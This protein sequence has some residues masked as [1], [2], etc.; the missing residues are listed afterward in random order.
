MLVARAFGHLPVLG[1]RAV[2]A[3]E[4]YCLPWT[5]AR[6]VAG[7]VANRLAR[8]PLMS[9][10]WK[11]RPVVFGLGLLDAVQNGRWE[12]AVPLIVLAVLTYTT[13][14]LDQAWMRKLDE[15]GD[16]RVIDEDLGPF[17]RIVLDPRLKA[18]RRRADVPLEARQ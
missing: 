17:A 12:A 1:S 18:D 13:G 5:I 7:K 15:L 14:P 10:S 16:H 2:L 8:T 6:A 4:I 3:V 11:L 9:F